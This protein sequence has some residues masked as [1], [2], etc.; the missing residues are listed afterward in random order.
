MNLLPDAKV[1]LQVEWVRDSGGTL[2]T[3]SRAKT[4]RG[5]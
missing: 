3:V 4:P 1:D 2:E 5:V